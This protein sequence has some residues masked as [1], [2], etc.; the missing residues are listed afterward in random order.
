MTDSM[1]ARNKATRTAILANWGFPAPSSF[2]TRVLQKYHEIYMDEQIDMK[3]IHYFKLK[4]M[5]SIGEG[6]KPC[7]SSKSV[8]YSEVQCRDCEAKSSKINVNEKLEL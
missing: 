8:W 5:L 7:S 2:E 3:S 4:N 6:Y 1:P